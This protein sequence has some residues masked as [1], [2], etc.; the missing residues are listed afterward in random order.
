MPI[1]LYD[2]A[3]A[4]ANRRF[5]P[6]CWRVRMAL[7]HKQLEVETIPWYFTE[8]DAI[9]FSG[10]GKVPVIVD[11]ARSVCDSWAIANYLDATYPNRPALFECSQARA[12]A[13]FVKHWD[14]RVVTPIMFPLL[15][16]DVF[17]HLHEKDQPYIKQTWEARS[18]KPL[19]DL[20]REQEDRL[21]QFRASM[22]PLREALSSQSFLAGVQP[23]FADHIVFG[24]LQWA[25][26]ISP[27]KLLEVN[28]PVYAWRERM[29]N[30]YDGLGSK[31][32]G[33]PV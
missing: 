21:G 28:D 8:K 26:C 6:Y 5:S 31:A 25:R 16:L 17:H 4:E 33:Y 1:K 10:Q 24:R 13:L 32:V 15:A 11:G 27:L 22:T 29:L 30:L 7:A 19:E 23:N 14:E 18:G 2:L 12:L 3:G 9:A 20:S